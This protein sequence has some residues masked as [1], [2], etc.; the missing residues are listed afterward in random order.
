MAA[1]NLIQLSEDLAYKLQDPV[2]TGQTNG[3]RWTADGR[4][5]Y[6]RRAYRRLYRTLAQLYPELMH[7]VFKNYYKIATVTTASSGTYDVSSYDEV[8]EV[9]VKFPTDEEWNRATYIS[10]EEYI[11]T[12]TG[13]SDFY[14]PDYNS[15]TFYWSILEDNIQ[16]LPQ[17]EYSMFFSFRD[18]IAA[19]L[20]YT[21]D[22]DID[23]PSEYWDLILSLAAAE[24]YM[25]IGQVDMVNLYKADVNEQLQLLAADKQRK[26]EN[27]EMA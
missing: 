17:L 14:N 8:F 21:G 23:I 2:A 24:A 5:G 6:L 16:V 11:S 1:P 9:F 27:D 18:D 7:T 12:Y 20:S 10:P 26:E 15:S 22:T 25:D 3:E 13:Y 4:L 19:S